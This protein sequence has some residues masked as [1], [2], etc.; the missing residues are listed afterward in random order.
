MTFIITAN[1]TYI[2]I[3]SDLHLRFRDG[4]LSPA[5][6]LIMLPLFRFSKLP[7]FDLLVDTDVGGILVVAE[8]VLA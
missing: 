7:I 3:Q 4:L 5:E 1:L 2:A 8:T 6:L